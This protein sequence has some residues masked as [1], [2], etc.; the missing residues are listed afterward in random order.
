MPVQLTALDYYPAGDDNKRIIRT[1]ED[2]ERMERHLLSS[3]FTVFDFETSGVNWFKKAR[4][5]GGALAT[6]GPDNRIWN[7]YVPFRHKSGEAQLDLSVVSPVFKRILGN[8]HSIKIAHNIKFDDH[9]AR[10]EEWFLGGYRYDTM[11][12][13]S[14]YDENQRLELESRALLLLGHKDPKY[15]DSRV[16]REISALAKRAGKN[17]TDYLDVHGYEELPINLCGTYACHDT[18]Y[19]AELYQY[20]EQRCGLSSAFPRIWQTEMALT[21]VLCDM[22]ESGLPVDVPYLEHL[23]DVLSAAKAG[24]EDFIASELG[25]G[26]NPGSDDQLRDLLFKQWKC[27]VIKFT[28]GKKPAVDAEVLAYFAPR[29]PVLRKIKEWR[30]ADKLESTYTRSIL[31]KTDERGICHSDF[32][33]VGTNTGRMACRAPNFQNL[34]QDDDARAIKYSGKPLKEGGVDPWSIRRAFIVRGK[35]RPRLYFDYSQIELRVLAFYSRDPIMVDNYMRGGDIHQR[36]MDEVSAMLGRPV[37]RRDAKVVNFGLAYCL[38]AEGLSRQAGMPIDE[39]EQFMAGFFERYRGIAEFRETFWKSIEESEGKSFRNIFGR[40]RRL[41]DI[42]SWQDWRR[43]RA[44]RQGIGSLVQ[45]TAAELT[46]ESLVRVSRWIKASGADAELVNVVHDDIQI[47]VHVGWL[48]SVARAAK[49]EME[50][51]PEFHPIPIT[52]D[53]DYSTTNWAEKKSLPLH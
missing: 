3:P 21:E 18:Q 48:A 31:D 35:D 52:V 15:W 50:A 29:I 27:P 2:L 9:F 47:D 51:Y 20:Y 41:A 22:E 44:Q 46:K 43:R 53:G 19:T 17:K 40:M 33:Q 23:Q 13:S 10:R 5:V 49:R 45:G 42:S 11:V 30:D 38:T 14:L 1:G 12:A 37:P 16:Q 39:A 26:F 36:T 6:W 34:P 8:P 32:K 7:Y 4:A 28:E 24:L 25:G